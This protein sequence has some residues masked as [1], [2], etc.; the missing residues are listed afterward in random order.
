MSNPISRLFGYFGRLFQS[1]VERVE[2]PSYALEQAYRQQLQALEETRRGRLEIETIA[3]RLELDDRHL[4]AGAAA[5]EHQAR[6]ALSAERSDLA[7]LSLARR[8]ELLEQVAQT[9]AERERLEEDRTQLQRQEAD[10]AGALQAFRS[11]KEVLK[12]QYG[13]ARARL[14]VGE[15]LTGYSKTVTGV[16]T[17]VRRFE[18]R[19]LTMQARARALEGVAVGPAIG[20]AIAPVYVERELIVAGVSPR[21]EEELHRLQGEVTGAP[22]VPQLEAVH[23]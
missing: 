9:H 7:R 5:C 4:T 20:S 10:I 6:R 22:N 18:D 21:V 17:D 13:A 16:G 3:A 11:R 1:G 23:G 12:A 2:D 8:E 19:L 14:R 15:A